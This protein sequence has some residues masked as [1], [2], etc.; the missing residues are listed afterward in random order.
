MSREGLDR[1]FLVWSG[2]AGREASPWVRVR[3]TAI[4]KGCI[5]M[6]FPHDRVLCSPAVY[7]V[8][9]SMRTTWGDHTAT[10]VFIMHLILVSNV[11]ELGSFVNSYLIYIP[12]M[13][14]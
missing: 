12:P 7:V 3:R 4:L 14:R 11:H 9:I 1:E 6:G 5:L 13:Q 8:Q 10:R 2:D